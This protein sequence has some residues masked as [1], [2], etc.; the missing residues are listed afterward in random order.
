MNGQGLEPEET[1]GPGA[2]KHPPTLTRTERARFIR[3][4]Y[5][6][7]SLMR[8]DP[9]EWDS[10]LQGMT[11]Q[12]LYYLGEMVELTQG[13]GMREIVP[14]PKLPLQPPDSLHS[15]T[16]SQPQKRFDLAQ[17]I[18]QQIQRISWRFFKVDAI[19]TSHCALYDG[20]PPFVVLWDHW[21]PCLEEVVFHGRRSASKPSPAEPCPA[22]TKQC[23]WNDGLDE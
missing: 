19:C 6:V 13:I 21:Q 18:W 22:E 11:S 9:S 23:L 16:H 10:R 15:I 14:P 1:Y 20:F 5:S 4:Y 2:R 8:V 7:W 3:S 17:R 12:E